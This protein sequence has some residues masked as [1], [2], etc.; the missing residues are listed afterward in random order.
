MNPSKKTAKAIWNVYDAWLH[1]YLNADHKTYDSFFDNSY[2][3][4]GSTNNEEFLN[5][6]ETTR[7]FELTGEQF[8]GLMDLRNETK[9]IEQFDELFYNSLL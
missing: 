1:A 6:K 8:S 9:I 3:F 7:F 4:I 2:H 5:R